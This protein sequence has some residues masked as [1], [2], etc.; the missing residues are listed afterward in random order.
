M[1]VVAL[2]GGVGG[3]R[4]VEGLGAVLPPED[5]T[6]PQDALPAEGGDAVAEPRSRRRRADQSD[7]HDAAV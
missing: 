1:K 6:V 4:L 7:A 5:L 3:A 2:S